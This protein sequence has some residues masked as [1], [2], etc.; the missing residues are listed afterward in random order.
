[1]EIRFSVQVMNI[2]PCKNKLRGPRLFR[3]DALARAG[4]TRNKSERIIPADGRRA[5]GPSYHLYVRFARVETARRQVIT[6]CTF[7]CCTSHPP[8]MIAWCSWKFHIARCNVSRA[9]ARRSGHSEDRITR[10]GDIASENV[11]IRER[12][13][14]N[15]D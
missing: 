10:G 2:P 9:Y 4:G 6:C 11:R 14:G 12:E 8:L 7:C 1:M 13:R 5:R 3:T 15:D